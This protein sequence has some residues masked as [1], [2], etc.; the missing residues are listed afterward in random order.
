MINASTATSPAIRAALSSSPSLPPLL[1]KVDR[2]RGAER[3]EALELLLGVK[4]NRGIPHGQRA[5]S[6]TASPEEIK[7]MKRLSQAVEKSVRGENADAL[8]L[9]WAEDR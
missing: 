9:D 7:A 8:G 4:A 6:F 5:T 1:R 3:E 2:L